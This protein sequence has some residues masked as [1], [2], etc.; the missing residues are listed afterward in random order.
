MGVANSLI[1]VRVPSA[2]VDRNETARLQIRARCARHQWRSELSR[3]IAAQAAAVAQRADGAGQR[4]ARMDGRCGGRMLS[5][6][7]LLLRLGPQLLV[8]P[9]S[10]RAKGVHPEHRR[11]LGEQFLHLGLVAGAER[12]QVGGVDEGRHGADALL[13]EA[14]VLAGFAHGD[15]DVVL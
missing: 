6:T 5:D 3:T 14:D 15:M 11:R 8:L 7:W 12:S 4:S 2:N 9:R 13:E 1:H 10:L